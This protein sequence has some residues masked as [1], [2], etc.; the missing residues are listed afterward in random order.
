MMLVLIF[1]PLQSEC[2]MSSFL[3]AVLKFTPLEYLVFWSFIYFLFSFRWLKFGFPEK[4]VTMPVNWKNYFWKILCDAE[5]L[6]NHIC[7]NI[8][9]FLN[10]KIF[11]ILIMF[12]YVHHY[13]KTWFKLAILKYLKHMASPRLQLG[14]ACFCWIKS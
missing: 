4:T 1:S 12:Q 5:D 10:I 13:F 2:E 6:S 7:E 3:S 8:Y 11:Q 9:I 14:S